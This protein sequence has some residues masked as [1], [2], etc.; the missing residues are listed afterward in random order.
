M[1]KWKFKRKPSTEIEAIHK[2]S[3]RS[4]E[5]NHVLGEQLGKLTRLQYKTGQDILGKLSIF[6][7]QIEVVLKW[8]EANKVE[9]TRSTESE[10]IIKE[11][12]T[13]L[14]AWLDDMDLVCAR[15]QDEEQAAWH[16]L[17]EHWSKHL[18]NTLALADVRE[19]HVLGTSFDP[20]WSESIGT[21]PRIAEDARTETTLSSAAMPYQ[22]VEVVKRG[23]MLGSG[24]LLRKAQVI[25]LLEE[26]PTE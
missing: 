19:L 22:I 18:L 8:Q 24:T 10:A 21:A 12:S 26:E 15:L 5:Q 4:D 23:Y 14:I 17:V 11:M 9:Q 2:L 25:T 1:W 7:E 6:N 13:A 20:R 3:E 16:Q